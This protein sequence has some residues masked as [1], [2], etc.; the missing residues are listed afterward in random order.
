MQRKVYCLK[1]C[2][3]TS[4]NPSCRSQKSRNIS[5]F[6]LFDRNEMD[7]A[8]HSFRNQG[9]SLRKLR[10]GVGILHLQQKNSCSIS[11]NN[12]FIC[13][14]QG[15]RLDPSSTSSTRLRRVK[16]KPGEHLLQ[17]GPA[18]PPVDNE[19]IKIIVYMQ[20]VCGAN[21]AFVI[22]SRALA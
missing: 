16:R 7:C 21:L 11:G 2:L 10:S 9:K 22:L 20:N 8:L 12:C 3:N 15:R 1:V 4:A 17:A 18:V 13:W 14:C 6:S 19:A 5:N